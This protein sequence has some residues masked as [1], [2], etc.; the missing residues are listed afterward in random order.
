MALVKL[1]KFVLKQT[2]F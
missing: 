2:Q 1:L